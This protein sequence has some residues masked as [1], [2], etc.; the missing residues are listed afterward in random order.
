[1]KVHKLAGGDQLAI[2]RIVG[3]MHVGTPN[4]DVLRAIFKRYWVIRGMLNR[5][6]VHPTM[7]M[8]RQRSVRRAV[9]KHALATHER[10]RRLYRKVMGGM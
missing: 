4:R 5:G 6:A 1:M 9:Y 8:W 10:N 2:E 3:A 7:G